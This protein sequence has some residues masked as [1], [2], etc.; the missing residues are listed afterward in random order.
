MQVLAQARRLYNVDPDRIFLMGHSMGAIGTWKVAAKY[1][2]VWAAIG[3]FSGQGAPSTVG[4][5]KHL[6]AFVVHGDNDP[7][8]N[9]R[10]SRTM[11][12]AMK[13]L[14]VDVTYVEVPGGNHTNMVEPNLAGMIQFFNT[15][16]K[17][18]PKSP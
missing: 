11:V 2:D 1:P 6:P 14:N 9:V 4:L 10:G 13:A 16:K 7:T 3:P 15:R 8:V 5:M 18:A 12:D 17:S